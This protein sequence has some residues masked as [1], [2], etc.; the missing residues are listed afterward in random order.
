MRLLPQSS[1]CSCSAGHSNLI[2]SG[3]RW[4]HGPVSGL[5]K[6]ISLEEERVSDAATL[7]SCGPCAMSEHLVE[8]IKPDS[9]GRLYGQVMSPGAVTYALL[10]S[11]HR[12]RVSHALP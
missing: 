8:F 1:S 9:C 12:P 4:A 5:F 10:L 7:A 6:G 11:G 3:P 2:L